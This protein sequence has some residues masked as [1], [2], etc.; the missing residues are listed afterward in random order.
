MRVILDGVFNHTGS[1]CEFFVKAKNDP[2]SKERN[3]YTWIAKGDD[4]IIRNPKFH[5][6][7]IEFSLKFLADGTFD[8]H[9]FFGVPTLPKLDFSD[10]KT[11]EEFIDGKD[12]VIRHWL[13]KGEFSAKFPLWNFRGNF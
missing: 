1:E 4:V 2:K 6:I 11:F 12:S 5:R 9:A 7:F 10:E 13:R 8:Y 3:M